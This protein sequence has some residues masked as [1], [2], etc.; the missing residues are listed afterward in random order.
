MEKKIIITL[1]RVFP[2]TY[3]R[4]GEHGTC[5]LRGSMQET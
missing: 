3:S 4:R 2:A 1:S 5:S